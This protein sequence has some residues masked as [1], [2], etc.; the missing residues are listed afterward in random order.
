MTQLELIAKAMQWSPQVYLFGGFAEDA[1]LHGKVARPHT[2]IDLLVFLDELELGFEHA[3]FL[4][5]RNFETRWQVTTRG[6][7]ATGCVSANI[8][9]EFCV[10]ERLE[11]G[12]AFF[13]TPA[14]EGGLHRNWLPEGALDF[15]RQHLDQVPVRVI[16]PLLLYQTRTILGEIFG[17]RLK[18]SLV[19]DEL[20]QRFF[21]NMSEVELAPRSEKLSK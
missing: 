5:F 10:M 2:D 16:S 14:A 13:D 9:L 12:R 7:L 18:D 1:L 19:Q 15:P 6:P 11:D 3:G 20:R 21:A 8:D 17:L 4:G